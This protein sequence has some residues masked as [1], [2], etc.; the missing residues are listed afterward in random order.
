[1]P[2]RSGYDGVF[3]SDVTGLPLAGLDIKVYNSSGTTLSTIYEGKSSS[4]TKEN[5]FST[6]SA[7]GGLVKFW[8]NPGYYEIEVSDGTGANRIGT[9]RIPFD[10][11]AGD[12]ITGNEGISLDQIP[13]VT[14]SK[15]GTSAI[16]ATKL[17]ALAVKS[18][19][20]DLKTYSTGVGDTKSADGDNLLNSQ[21]S[22]PAGTYLAIGEVKLSVSSGTFYYEFPRFVI[23]SGSATVTYNDFNAIPEYIVDS[24]TT[25][26]TEVVSH[27]AIIAVTSTAT[28]QQKIIHVGSGKDSRGGFILIGIAS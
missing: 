12:T 23:S 10:A 5:P 11:V 1:M 28:I 4:A 22:V 2:Q 20:V 19:K 26:K 13:V 21:A 3:I 9:R 14:E 15:I 7:N 6:T 8:V 25:A 16:S 27:A 18:G 17:G 24:D